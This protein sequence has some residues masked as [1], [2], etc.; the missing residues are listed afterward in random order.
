MTF[1]IPS[2]APSVAKRPGSGLLPIFAAALVAAL[3]MLAQPAAAQQQA[4]ASAQY[5]EEQ[6]EA[7]A[8]AT[9]KVEQL[10]AKWTP[11]IAEAQTP[12][13]NAARREQAMQEMRSAVRDEGLSVEQYNSIYELSQR[14]P[15]VMQTIEEHRDSLQ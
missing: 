12:D 7:F 5:S 3:S 11:Q 15:E 10:S 2:S 14:D 8:S 13:E 9:L 4:P 6:L 1:P